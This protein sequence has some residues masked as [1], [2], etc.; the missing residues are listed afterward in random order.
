VTQLQSRT[1][2]LPQLIETA[3]QPTLHRHGTDLQ[4]LAGAP[5]TP[6]GQHHALEHL[7]LLWRQSTQQLHRIHTGIADRLFNG[8]ETGGS[9]FVALQ[10]IEG[11]RTPTRPGSQKPLPL[12]LR[13]AELE[14]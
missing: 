2:A 11:Q 13:Q 9:L 3:S 12:L 10:V 4:G 6:T 5:V 14:P 1:E 7:T 8:M